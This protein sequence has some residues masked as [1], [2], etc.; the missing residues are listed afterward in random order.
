MLSDNTT[1]RRLGDSNAERGAERSG[2]A[3]GCDAPERAV[4]EG[5]RWC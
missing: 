2:E 3:L 4:L 1:R 5:W